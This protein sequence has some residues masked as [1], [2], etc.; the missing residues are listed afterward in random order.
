[1]STKIK[2]ILLFFGSFAFISTSCQPDY[3]TNSYEQQ[4][5]IPGNDHPI[6]GKWKK[7]GIT[8]YAEENIAQH[9]HECETIYDYIQYF[10]NGTVRDV[11]YL[12]DCVTTEE[13]NGAYIISGNILTIQG[14]DSGGNLVTGQLTITELTAIT[15][16]VKVPE[17]GFIILYE[18]Y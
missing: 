18:K 7:V 16:K 10:A 13:D 2:L 14:F 12:E 11:G 8:D 17:M 6:V 15:L 5:P 4:N 9:Y 1:M 3:V